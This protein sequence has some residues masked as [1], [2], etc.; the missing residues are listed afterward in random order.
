MNI[1]EKNSHVVLN[2][3]SPNHGRGTGVE[4]ECDSLQGGEV[5]ADLSESRVDQDIADGNQDDQSERVQ[6]VHDIVGEAVEFH[7]GGLGDKIVVDLV[8]AE[9]PEREPNEDGAGVETTTDFIDPGVVECH[10]AWAVRPG[11]VGGFG[12]FPHCAVVEVFETALVSLVV[13]ID[14]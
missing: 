8:V 5:D 1:E 11:D 13:W 7:D 14:C 10:P 12:G 4:A 2:E 3:T 6:V 9:P